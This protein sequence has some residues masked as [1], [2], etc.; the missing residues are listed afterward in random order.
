MV[1]RNPQKA[2]WDEIE[3]SQS[4]QTVKFKECFLPSFH[5]VSSHSFH[6]NDNCHDA[7][8]HLDSVAMVWI[9][10]SISWHCCFAF[11]LT[12][13]EGMLVTMKNQGKGGKQISGFNNQNFMKK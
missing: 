3:V 13:A 4:S 10:F 9:F 1:E 7:V 12:G 5:F 2:I 6:L 11:M 8:V